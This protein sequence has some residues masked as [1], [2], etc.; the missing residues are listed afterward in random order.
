MRLQEFRCF[1]SVSSPTVC[2]PPSTT[3]SAETLAADN[4]EDPYGGKG[5]GWKGQKLCSNTTN[6]SEQGMIWKSLLSQFDEF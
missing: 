5:T 1:I 4:M 3:S 2:A 6:K